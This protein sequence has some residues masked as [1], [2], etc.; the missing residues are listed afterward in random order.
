[1]NY[2]R[3][4]RV[5]AITDKKNRD[6][7]NHLSHPDFVPS[8]SA[9]SYCTPGIVFWLDESGIEVPGAECILAE[10]HFWTHQRQDGVFICPVEFD[11][12]N[13]RYV[14]ILESQLR[15]SGRR[16]V[17]GQNCNATICNISSL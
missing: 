15:S 8:L 2:W 16:W 11:W 1:M 13:G 7:L 12:D 4:Y 6:S 5:V 14:G 9:P 10:S 17:N 3:I